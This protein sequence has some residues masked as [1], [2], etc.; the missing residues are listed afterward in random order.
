M[1]WLPSLILLVACGPSLADRSPMTS[2]DTPS[3]IAPAPANTTAAVQAPGESALPARGARTTWELA[4]IAMPE[5][6]LSPDGDGW[7]KARDALEL[8]LPYLAPGLPMGAV[9]AWAQGPFKDWVQVRMQFTREAT[10]A[11]AREAESSDERVEGQAMAG[12]LMHQFSV[13]FLGA[14]VPREIESDPELRRIYEGALLEQSQPLVSVALEHYERCE[15]MEANIEWR[16]FCRDRRREL[17]SIADEENQ[18]RAEALPELREAA[19]LEAIGRPP[20]G[21]AACWGPPPGGTPSPA[22]GSSGPPVQVGVLGT[23]GS[24]AVGAVAPPSQSPTTIP[25]DVVLAVAPLGAT[26]Q[27]PLEARERARL[28]R[29]V[30][31]ELGSLVAGQLTRWRAA[32]SAT[33][34]WRREMPCRSTVGSLEAVRQA[35]PTEQVGELAFVCPSPDICEVRVTV[36]P[37]HESGGEVIATVVGEVEGDPL[38]MAAWTEAIGAME[39][40]GSGLALTRVGGVPVWEV[41]TFG[42]PEW[43]AEMDGLQQALA[44]CTVERRIELGV[45]YRIDRRGRARITT[46][47]DGLPDCVNEAIRSQEFDAGAERALTV[48]TRLEPQPPAARDQA[49]GA[50]VGEGVRARVSGLDVG[51][52]LNEALA[53]CQRTHGSDEGAVGVRG[54]VAFG[55]DGKGQTAELAALGAST[56]YLDCV[57]QALLSVVDR[58]GAHDRAVVICTYPE[59]GG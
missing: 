34:R 26:A 46:S 59:P 28:V 35:H 51:P 32:R 17:A 8:H 25:G 13:R 14:P 47:E 40:F 22:T 53:R 49:Y 7:T 3:P 29:R 12:L 16:L 21:P 39:L 24:G 27:A 41:A 33:A 23:L 9:N 54:T 57:R 48:A 30:E 18:I 10:D 6:T 5:R 55:A 20:P 45:L 15:R 58:C 52:A 56:A 42:P 50:L 2:D 37:P 44:A 19:R 36:H 31:R 11:F 38:T 1:R 43:R 4:G